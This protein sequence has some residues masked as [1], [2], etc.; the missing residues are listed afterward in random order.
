MENVI[1]KL[2]D[3]INLKESKCDFKC[4]QCP[5]NKVVKEIWYDC[6]Y[7]EIDICRALDLIENAL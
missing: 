1:S 3:I 5:L 6:D 4:S 2:R 7:E